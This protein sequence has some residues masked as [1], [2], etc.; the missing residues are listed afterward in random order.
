[1]PEPGKQSINYFHFAVW[2]NYCH[3][4]VLQWWYVGF[5]LIVLVVQD[6][7]IAYVASTDIRNQIHYLSNKTPITF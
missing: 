6:L 5:H 3:S 7:L 2:K 4:Y 1:M